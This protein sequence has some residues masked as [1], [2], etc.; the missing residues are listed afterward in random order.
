VNVDS[1]LLFDQIGGEL[2]QTSA[3]NLKIEVTCKTDQSRQIFALNQG[4][5]NRTISKIIPSLGNVKN[6][7]QGSSAGSPGMTDSHCVRPK[8]DRNYQDHLFRSVSR[9]RR[10]V[11]STSAV[12]ASQYRRMSL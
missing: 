4:E 10:S 12:N 7:L 3:F 2:D 8:I 1:R 5:G 6:F 11:K 9:I